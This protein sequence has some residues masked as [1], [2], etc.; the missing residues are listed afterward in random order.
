MTIKLKEV[1]HER[2]IIDLI[3]ASE[4]NSFYKNL[5][6]EFGIDKCYVHPELYDALMQL[7]PVLE[8]EK[9]KL[10]I[11]D[12]LRPWAVQK[13]MYDT[14][15]DYLK[16]YLAPPP[17]PGARRGFHPRGVAIDCYLADENGVSLDFPTAPDAFYH[18]YENDENY[19]EYLKRV[20]R[21]YDGDDVTQEQVSNKDKL[22]KMMV[23]VGLE[24]LPSEWWHFNIPNA[25]DYPI[26]YSLDDCEII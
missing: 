6:K 15:P 16:P 20:S 21:S 5:Y 26:I 12:T 23:D 10:V 1:N 24:P 14:A 7:V 13:F 22:E 4:N 9:L 19:M 3:Y 8:K 25:F 18:G 17:E 2:F 11:Y